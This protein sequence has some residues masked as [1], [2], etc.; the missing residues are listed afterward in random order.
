MKRLASLITGLFLLTLAAVPSADA[1]A[2]TVNGRS[3]QFFDQ[4]IRVTPRVIDRSIE[5]EVRSAHTAT[6]R[7]TQLPKFF[8]E[9]YKANICFLETKHCAIVRSAGGQTR[10]ECF[11][12]SPALE[13]SKNR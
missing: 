9:S 7:A 8:K 11:Q 3:F 13:C 4:L 10:S 5:P 1:A 2:A 12:F 6:D